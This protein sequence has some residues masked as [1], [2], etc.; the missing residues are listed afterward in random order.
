VIPE[1]TPDL[2]ESLVSQGFFTFDDLS[3][4]EPDQLGEISGLTPEDCD[5]IIEYADVESLKAE[6]RDR[7]A[8]EQRKQSGGYRDSREQSGSGRPNRGSSGS[9]SNDESYDGGESGPRE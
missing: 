9:P 1:V 6:E 7:A 3:V 5:R 8:A 4:I 2:A